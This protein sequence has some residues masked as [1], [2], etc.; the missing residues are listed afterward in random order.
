M[1]NKSRQMNKCKFYNFKNFGIKTRETQNI[2]PI[3]YSFL[4]RV[5]DSVKFSRK[6]KKIDSTHFMVASYFVIGSGGSRIW[7]IMLK[8]FYTIF[9]QCLLT[10]NFLLVYLLLYGIS[11][12]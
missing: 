6:I 2:S 12:G 5:L 4:C 1:I 11:L 9:R 8:F 3:P 7:K 10:S